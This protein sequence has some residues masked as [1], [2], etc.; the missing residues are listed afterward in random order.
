MAFKAMD[1]DRATYRLE[2]DKRGP[3]EAP[4]SPPVLSGWAEV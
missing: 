4:W 1:L 2:V 3:R